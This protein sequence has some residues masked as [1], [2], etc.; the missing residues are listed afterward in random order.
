MKLKFIQA[1]VAGLMLSVC[2]V[3]NAGLITTTFTSNDFLS[4]PGSG[5]SGPA[6]LYPSTIEVSNL[7][8]SIVDINVSL[9]G[10][11]STW[12]D[13]LIIA[14][15]N[16]LNDAVYLMH[17]ADGSGDINNINLIFDDQ[18]LGL[19]SNYGQI[20]TGSYQV[21]KYGAYNPPFYGGFS[22][23]YGSDLSHFNGTARN[24]SYKLYIADVYTGDVGSLQ[25]WSI[26][27]TTEQIEVPEPSTLTIFALGIMGLASRRFK[28]Q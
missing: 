10:L 19:L 6:S 24:G 9:I 22:G 14:L 26:E 21:S 4:I 5:T 13:D 17:S 1:A 8:G 7:L 12:P 23:I 11:T 28:K 15:L 20:R 25:G 2:S 18:A 3:A 27:I 16:P